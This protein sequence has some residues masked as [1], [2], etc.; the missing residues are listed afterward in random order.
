MARNI[1]GFATTHVGKVLR[2]CEDSVGRDKV[3]ILAGRDRPANRRVYVAVGA[4]V[5]DSARREALSRCRATLVVIDALPELARVDGI[6]VLDSEG[7]G[8][9]RPRRPLF[10][11]L[12]RSLRAR[13]SRLEVSLSPDRALDNLVSEVRSRG[14]LDTVLAFAKPLRPEERAVVHT[15]VARYMAGDINL[16]TLRRRAMG[17]A[18]AP[19]TPTSEAM[20]SALQSP[21]AQRLGR[22]LADHRRGDDV[23]VAARRHNV[24]SFELRFMA[25]HLGGVASRSRST[26]DAHRG[27]QRGRARRVRPDHG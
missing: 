19:K 1:F 24:D 14:I 7:D 17:G 18:G 21:T 5:L 22:A 10:G 2:V 15:C 13:P 23:S 27:R 26:R 4:Q 6:R 25:A 9:W 3:Q 12:L 8:A 16:G 11:T 20:L